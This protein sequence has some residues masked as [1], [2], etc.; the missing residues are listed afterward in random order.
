MTLQQHVWNALASSFA[1]LI[2]VMSPNVMLTL[3]SLDYSIAPP[4][5]MLYLQNQI[6]VLVQQVVT[7]TTISA[8]IISLFVVKR[9]A[10]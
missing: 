6:E 3:F 9:A 5:I 2:V 7:T 10:I 8:D 4:G 1:V